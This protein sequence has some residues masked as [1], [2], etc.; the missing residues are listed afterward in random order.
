MTQ[1]TLIVGD[2]QLLEATSLVKELLDATVAAQLLEVGIQGPPGP[3]GIPGSPAGITV[4]ADANPLVVDL[5][6]RYKTYRINLVGN[7]A[8]QVIGDATVDGLGFIIEVTM[9]APGGWVISYP[10]GCGLSFTGDIPSVPLASVTGNK[11]YFGIEYIQALSAADV[12]AYK[13]SF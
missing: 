12:M 10:G 3:A 7:R 1:E 2:I 4:V 11:T 6:L 8:I 9:G 5:R 13:R